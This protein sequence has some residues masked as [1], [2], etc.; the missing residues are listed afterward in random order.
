MKAAVFVWKSNMFSGK[1]YIRQK[2][3][4]ETIINGQWEGR[5][6]CLSCLVLVINTCSGLQQAA[7]PF[8]RSRVYSFSPA[9]FQTFS[10]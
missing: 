2:L 3:I 1:T 7:E 6:Q 8:D 5:E 4:I 9:E 10:C